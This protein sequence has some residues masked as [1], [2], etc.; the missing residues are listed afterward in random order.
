MS[1]TLENLPSEFE[2]FR[3]EFRRFLNL[4]ENKLQ[5]EEP[6]E[7]LPLT[8][9]EASKIVGYTVPTL[10]GYCQRNAIP[11]HKKNNRLFFFK[12]ELIDWIKQSKIKTRAEIKEEVH[13]YLTPKK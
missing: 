9:K 2:Q 3:E 4:F 12:S 7:D 1:I 6:Q 11:Y 13:T 10:Y 8:I 5:P